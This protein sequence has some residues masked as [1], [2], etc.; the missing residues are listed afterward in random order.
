MQTHGEKK[1]LLP[2]SGTETRPFDFQSL[3]Y[4]PYRQ[5]YTRYEY[6][7]PYMNQT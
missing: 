4:S 1:N 5:S 7:F 2:Q 6:L 3:G